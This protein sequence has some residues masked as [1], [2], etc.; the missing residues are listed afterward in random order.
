MNS[1]NELFKVNLK[2]VYRNRSG[3]FWTVLMPTFIYSALSVLPLGRSLADGNLKYSNYLLPGLI[4]MVIMQSGI[5]G[6]AYW[7][8][9][10]KARGVIKRFL[11]TPLKLWQMALA[12]V[13][14]RLVVIVA[15]VIVLTLLG[16][17]VFNAEFMG[18]VLSV[19][20]F[21]LL[22]GG[23]FLLLGLLISN[24]ANSYETAAPITSAI[25]LPLTFLG[26]IFYPIEVLPRG[27]QLFAKCLPITYLADG[28][29][30]SY[31][32][33]FE[34]EKI[35]KDLLILAAWLIGVLLITFKVFRL[36]E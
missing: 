8:T 26:N 11:A 23:I 15:Q 17:L 1:F 4:A 34:F 19:L 33:A 27:L 29:R 6:L 12:V 22:G 28:L 30:Q 9:D 35:S 13:A 21:V 5:Y 7:M 32:Y 10:L 24:F 2:I 14:S 20:A 16:V 25:G 36:K 3:L 18:N 31:L